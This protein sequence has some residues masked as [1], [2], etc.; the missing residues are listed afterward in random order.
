[1]RLVWV[2]WLPVSAALVL[3]G[4]L[5]ALPAPRRMAAV[6]APAASARSGAGGSGGADLP[7]LA[8]TW[9]RARPLALPDPPDGSV[10]SPQL[11]LSATTTVG[12]ATSPDG[13]QA[14]LVAASADGRTRVVQ[15]AAGGL[16]QGVMLAAGRLYWML[17]A[18]D[19][20]GRVGVGLW[21][22]A[23]DGGPAVLLTSDV[24]L[25]L[26][27]GPGQGM[28]VMGG[29]LYWTATQAGGARLGPPQGPTQLRSVALSGGPVQ[30]RTVPGVWTMSGWPWLVTAP[31][32]GA[33]PA[34]YDLDHS[35]AT[36]VAVP[37]GYRQVSCGPAWCVAVGDAGV[38]LVRPDG[39][40]PRPL[41][42]AGST[43]A[44]GEVV[45]V[46]RYA[47]LLSPA[48]AGRRLV[49]YDITAH[50]LVV[51]AS[52]VTDAGSDGRYLWW[53]TGDHEALRWHGLD[54][55]SLR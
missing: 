28:P 1:V 14:A 31:D 51:V 53:S 13:R 50:R 6:P 12:V 45:L 16:F 36:A 7:G 22:A 8:G 20:S 5:V 39:S 9:P 29:R 23:P 47:P 32:T 2:R 10:F 54:L 55:E 38:E 49:L 41:P 21:S 46:N 15:T 43:P 42:G 17:T 48:G 4:V 40:D 34:R 37:A 27:P 3:I 26:L 30:V 18:A 19:A 25:P 44:T 11:V 35:L 24:G 52:A 33:A